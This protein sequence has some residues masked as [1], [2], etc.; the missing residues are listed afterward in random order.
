MVNGTMTYFMDVIGSDNPHNILEY[1][2]PYKDGKMDTT[3]E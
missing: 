2:G 3:N 1:S